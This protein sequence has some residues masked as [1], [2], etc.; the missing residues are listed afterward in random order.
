MG[1]R[2]LLDPR[3]HW[4]RSALQRLYAELD[5]D[6]VPS[7][8]TIIAANGEEMMSYST[9]PGINGIDRRLIASPSALMAAAEATTIDVTPDEVNV[10]D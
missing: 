9:A 10:D 5:D 3:W 1:G 2:Q 6:A 8:L 4:L 7:C